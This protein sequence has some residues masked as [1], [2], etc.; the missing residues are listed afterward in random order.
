MS[1]FKLTQWF[2]TNMSGFQA[3]KGFYKLL[4]WLR[5]DHET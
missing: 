2:S 5:I 3:E 4:F 1:W